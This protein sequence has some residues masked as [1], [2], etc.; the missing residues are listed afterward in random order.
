MS[1]ISLWIAFG[2]GSLFGFL[3]FWTAERVASR[4]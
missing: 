2:L 4:D 1:L 3:L